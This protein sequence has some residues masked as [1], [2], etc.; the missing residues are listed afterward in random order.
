M[1]KTVLSCGGYPPC[2]VFSGPFPPA[3]PWLG[4]GWAES[5]SQCEMCW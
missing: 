3:F 1:G 5:A 4:K 2:L